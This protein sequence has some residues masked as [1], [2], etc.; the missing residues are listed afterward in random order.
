M[1]EY[2]KK[3]DEEYEKRKKENPETALPS[4]METQKEQENQ[5]K[6]QVQ[7]L[8]ET[9]KEQTEQV[10]TQKQQATNPTNI[11]S[12]NTAQIANGQLQAQTQNDKNIVNNSV[13]T[14]TAAKAAQTATQGNSGVDYNNWT[15]EGWKS[16]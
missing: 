1:S 5:Q 6:E 4:Y 11:P 8:A 13:P 15:V 7:N 3:R 12:T 9:Q 16:R 14:D 2:Y 10:E